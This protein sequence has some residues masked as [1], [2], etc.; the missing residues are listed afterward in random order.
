[1]GR[2]L[3][4]WL[5]VPVLMMVILFTLPIILPMVAV[6]QWRDE[7]RLRAA[8]RHAACPACGALLGLAALDRAKKV[9]A[10]YLATF[11]LAHPYGIIPRIP[12][13]ADAVCAVCGVECDFD[14]KRRVFSLRPEWDPSKPG[15]AGPGDDPERDAHGAAVPG[16]E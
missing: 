11:R 16:L 1:M 8:V 2:W 4:L 14:A 10:E 5:V 7:R 6:L 12:P 9:Q 13:P 3:P 15:Q